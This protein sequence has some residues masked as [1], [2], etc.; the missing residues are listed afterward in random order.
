MFCHLDYEWVN[1]DESANI[2]IN[3]VKLCLYKDINELKL[4]QAV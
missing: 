1:E 3:V 2:P 4:P